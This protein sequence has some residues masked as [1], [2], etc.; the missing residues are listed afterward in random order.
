MKSLLKPLALV[1]L[2][3]LVS[4][5]AGA[6][7]YGTFAS[8]YSAGGLGFWGWTG[9]VFGT[10]AVGA[11][12]L[13]TFGGGAAAAPAW[14]AAV[15]TWIGSTVGLSGIAAANFGLAL[16][17]GGAVAA[18]GLGVA[19]GVTVLASA[20]AFST[21]IVLSYSVDAALEKYTH[22]K[23]IEAN[24][25]MLTLPV[26]RN[27]KGGK[28]YKAAM[29]HLEKKFNSQESLTSETNQQ[30]LLRAIEILN[31]K[32]YDETDNSYRLKDNTLLALLHLQTNNY[33]EARNAAQNAIS[34][35]TDA[36]KKHNMPYFIHALAQL[37][38]PEQGCSD[39]TLSSLQIAYL[40]EPD[41]KLIPLMTGSCM[42]RLMYAY[43]HGKLNASQLSDFCNLVAASQINSKLAAQSLEIFVT[44]SLLL[45]KDTQQL[46]R[47]VAQD[48]SMIK[49]KKVRAELRKRLER[50]K[51]LVE[52]LWDT[53]LPQVML[54][55]K[56][57]AKDS[58]VK[59]EELSTLLSQYREEVAELQTLIGG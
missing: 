52:L 1:A 37:A 57:F 20:L 51:L 8:F 50:H 56:E 38:D 9:I 34:I 47:T 18:G 44:R 41:N 19:G 33:A 59:S 24:K 28:A 36:D 35:G 4:S 21:D 25:Q 30:V 15:G 32:M 48:S 58:K 46:I 5:H 53:A 29:A 27:T 10:I 22:A 16:L 17:G 11:L 40:Q 6:A 42:D 39:E 14:M 43:R 13:F 2:L 3:V 49:Q 31:E 55:E 45:L 12:T 54:L 7:E 23:F 26:P